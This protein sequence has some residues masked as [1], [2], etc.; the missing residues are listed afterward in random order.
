M[1]I[2][3]KALMVIMFC[4]PLTGAGAEEGWRP[5]FNGKDLSGWT[6]KIRGLP[7]GEDPLETFRVQDAAITVSYENYE[8]FDNRFGHLFFEE[9]F[10]HYRLR[11]EYRFIGDQAPGGEAWAYKNSGV[12]VHSQAP[13]T[14]P[15]AQD[16]PISVEVQFLGG[17]KA[18]KPRP[19]ANMCSPGTHIEY[20]GTFTDTHCIAS[21]APTFYGD[22][23]I[24][25]EVL[26]L[27]GEQVVH[28]VN[29]ERVMAYGGL[30][31][32]GGVV[33][34][35]DPAMKPE[36][37]PLTKGYISLQSESHPIQFRKIEILPL[38]QQGH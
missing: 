27:G 21:S 33:S 22:E 20:Q 24:Q 7:A 35:H 29:G 38:P 34:G 9:E 28:Y 10:S 26:V 11:L 15:P 14:M 12:M 4:A 3:L 31:T 1:R 32:G 16:F 37:A 13:S 23:W 25:M 5:L 19:T 17:A 2:V 18:G 6:P 36:R 8:A 30:V